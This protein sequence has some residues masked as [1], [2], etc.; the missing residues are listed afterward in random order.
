[1]I[2]CIMIPKPWWTELP[3]GI[4]PGMSLTLK[5]QHHGTLEGSCLWK[6]CHH[7]IISPTSTLHTQATYINSS[8]INGRTSFMY[9][10]TL[11]LLWNSNLGEVRLILNCCIG[12][13]MKWQL[14][15]LQGCFHFH[16][17]FLMWERRYY[18]YIYIYIYIYGESQVGCFDRNNSVLRKV[19]ALAV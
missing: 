4:S 2:L 19:E 3:R 18:I 10:K 8:F 12:R 17:F 11:M 15:L 9:L 1:M 16:F 14:F 13:H 7:K 5:P 6:P